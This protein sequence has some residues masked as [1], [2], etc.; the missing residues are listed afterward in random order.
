VAL[1]SGIGQ[2]GSPFAILFGTSAPLPLMDVL[3]R[4]PGGASEHRER[5]AAATRETVSAGF[6][7][8]A[9]EAEIVGVGAAEWP[10]WPFRI[11][12]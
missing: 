8:D 12:Y 9:D 7:L 2:G 5:F 1:H 6:L 3:A 11:M 10:L 4:F